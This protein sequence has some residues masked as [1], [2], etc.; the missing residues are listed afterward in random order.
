MTTKMTIEIT[1]AISLQLDYD[2]HWRLW[3][4]I[5]LIRNRSQTIMESQ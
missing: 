4:L 1:I 3:T 5:I 2:S